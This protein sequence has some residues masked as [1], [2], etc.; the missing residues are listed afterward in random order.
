VLCLAS[1]FQQFAFNYSTS[2]K[3]AF[4]TALYM[5]L[6]P[7]FGLVIRKRV[8]LLTWLCVIIGFVGLGFLCVDPTDLTNINFGDVLAAVGAVFYAVQI[9]MIERFS[10]KCY[11]ILLSFTQFLVSGLISCCLMFLLESPD[12]SAVWAAIVPILYSGVMSCGVAY[13]L[14]IV[15]QKYTEAT[16]AS[17]LMCLESVFGVLC[18]ALLLK[19]MLTV[20]EILGCVIMFAAIILSQLS[21]RISFKRR[22]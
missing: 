22:Q 21:D 1:N 3:I 18:G 20:P 12:L 4:V 9:L 2:G 11:D 15:G 13:T 5:F 17:L 14:Q 16:V 10:D 19:E 7:I 6:V 8:P